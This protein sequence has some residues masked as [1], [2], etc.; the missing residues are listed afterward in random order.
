MQRLKLI[1]GQY[2]SRGEWLHFAPLQYIGAA[3]L[4]LAAKV[5]EQPQKLEYVARMFHSCTNRDLPDI[6]PTSEVC[7]LEESSIY[8]LLVTGNYF[9]QWS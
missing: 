6:D 4:F 5:E 3:A 2:R 8:N 9:V 7:Y 1:A